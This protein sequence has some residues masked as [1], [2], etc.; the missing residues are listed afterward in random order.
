MCVFL[1]FF[2]VLLPFKFRLLLVK[3]HQLCP[4][5]GNKAKYKY[6]LLAFRMVW[7]SLLCNKAYPIKA[8]ILSYHSSSTL[9][10]LIF[11]SLSFSFHRTINV[12]IRI[13]CHKISLRCVSDMSI[14]RHIAP[15]IC[16]LTS[17]EPTRTVTCTLVTCQWLPQSDWLGRV[18]SSKYNTKHIKT[19]QFAKHKKV[20]TGKRVK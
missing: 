11:K 6:V 15:V 8:F 13:S 3:L 20:V 12:R 1:F 18:L 2:F 16:L 14:E 9:F 4:I 17:S 10:F 5:L 19:Q 7:N